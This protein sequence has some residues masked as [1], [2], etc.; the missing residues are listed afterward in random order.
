[1]V[2]FT[3]PLTSPALDMLIQCKKSLKNV[4]IYK[5]KGLHLL[6]SSQTVFPEVLAGVGKEKQS[7]YCRL[8]FVCSHLSCCHFNESISV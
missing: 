6:S 4:F 2:T 5:I 3:L 7:G 8:T 1:M